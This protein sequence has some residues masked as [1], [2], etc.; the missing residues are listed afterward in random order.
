MTKTIPATAAALLLSA[1]AALAGPATIWAVDVTATGGGVANSA[2]AE[3]F[4]TDGS[5][6]RQVNL[7]AG[8]S[9]GGIAL[10][11]NTGYVSSTTDGLIRSFDLSTGALGSSFSS[12]KAALGSLSA[13][14]NGLWAN[15]YGGGNFA[16]HFTFAGVNDQSVRLANCGSFCNA[17]EYYRIGTNGFLLANRG[18]TE[19]PAAYDVYTTTGTLVQAGLISG[20]PTGAGAAYDPMASLFYVSNVFD[21]TL[22]TY[23]LN[24]TAAGTVTLGGTAPDT[25]FQTDFPGQRFVSDLAIAAATATPVPEPATLGMLGGLLGVAGLLRQRRAARTA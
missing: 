9:P 4:A 21:G 10:V 25:G 1:G 13:D 20:V 8:F 11:G 18:E 7:G 23:N 17:I 6:L 12:G 24:G 19:D 3:Q 22:Q 14:G 2:F 5:L 15:D 16:F